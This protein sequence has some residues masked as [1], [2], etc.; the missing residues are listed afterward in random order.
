[1][2]T[3]IFIYHDQSHGV[4][5]KNPR[6]AGS[7]ENTT[8]NLRRNAWL[9]SSLGEI[10]VCGWE[11]LGWYVLRVYLQEFSLTSKPAKKMCKMEQDI[12]P[13]WS[14]SPPKIAHIHSKNSFR[15]VPESKGL[16]T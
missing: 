3:P 4:A 16:K 10:T 13:S 8:V 5:K 12:S 14:L 11:L 15:S 1:M 7:I 2:K 9:E 6:L